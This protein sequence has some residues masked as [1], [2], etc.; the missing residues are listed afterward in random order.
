M[1]RNMRPNQPIEY[2]S[3]PIKPKKRSKQK[4][5]NVVIKIIISINFFSILGDP[6]VIM[7]IFLR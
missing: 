3:K 1:R 4:K 6:E 7:K 2:R 5:Q